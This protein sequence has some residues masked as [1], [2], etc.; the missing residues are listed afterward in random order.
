MNSLWVIRNR[1]GH[2]IGA[3]TTQEN[4]GG[5]RMAHMLPAICEMMYCTAT[6]EEDTAFAVFPATMQPRFEEW[7]PNESVG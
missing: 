2:V 7:M 6:L 3:I 5:E 4:T 1:A